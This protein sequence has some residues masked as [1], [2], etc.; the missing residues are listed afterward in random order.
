MN[1]LEISEMK[2]EESLLRKEIHRFAKEIVRP[3]ADELDKMPSEKTAEEDSPY[4]DVLEQMKEMGLHKIWVPEEFGGEELPPKQIHIIYEELGWGSAGLGTSIGVDCIPPTVLALVGTDEAKEKFLEPWM[5]DEK[6]QFHGCWAVTEPEHG[7]DW[8]IAPSV[9]QPE[10]Y[11]KAEV[12]AEKDDDGWVIN[13]NKAGWISS[14][15]CA[16]HALTHVGFPEKDYSMAEAGLVLVPLDIDGVSKGNPVDML[17][18]RDDPQGELT[19]ENVRI[20]EINMIFQESGFYKLFVN[21]LICATSSFMGA[22]FTGVA[23]AA[24][25]EAY[26]YANERVQGGKPLIEHNLVKKKLYELFQ[27]VQTSRH[28]TRQVMKHTWRKVINEKTLDASVPHGLSAQIVGTNTA[29]EVAHEALQLFGGYGL[30][31]EYLIEKLYRDARCSL[32]M[33]GSNDLLTLSGAHEL[34]NTYQT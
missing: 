21:Q 20:P 28:H 18:M 5:E 12:K 17:G 34:T 9:S 26:Q 3:A 27:K 16:T 24:F 31:K 33:D 30:S 25:E 6:N 13:G 7:S 4:W 1:F 11:G 8:L 19:F 22:L 2:E 15:P 10:K 14:A 29:Y 32:I 23:R